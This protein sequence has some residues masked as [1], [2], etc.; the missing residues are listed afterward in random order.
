MSRSSSAVKAV[1][2]G[3][4]GEQSASSRAPRTTGSSMARVGM[5][6]VDA[7]QRTGTPTPDT[8]WT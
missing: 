3:F 4:C 6:R 8:R 1:P 2:V 5:K 7:S